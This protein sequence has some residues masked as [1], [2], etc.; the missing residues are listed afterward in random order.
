MFEDIESLITVSSAISSPETGISVHFKDKEIQYLEKIITTI[1]EF[2]K[3]LE[4]RISH[5]KDL[6]E[7]CYYGNLVMAYEKIIDELED[8]QKGINL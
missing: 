1:K 7:R 3:D 6:I 4:R 5:Y 8:I 2:K